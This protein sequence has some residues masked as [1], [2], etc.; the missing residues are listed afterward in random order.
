MSKNAN[1]NYAGVYDQKL[2]YGKKP[3]LILVDF[4]QAYFDPACDLFG[5]VDTE[6]RAFQ[7]PVA[8]RIKRLIDSSRLQTAGMRRR[9]IQSER[10]EYRRGHPRSSKSDP[11]ENRSSGPL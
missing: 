1:E 3:A 9:A 6:T 10:R 7:H 5:D 8:F 2:G 11:T 4:V